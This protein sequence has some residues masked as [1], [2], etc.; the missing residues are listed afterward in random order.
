MQT[1]KECLTGRNKPSLG[2][3]LKKQKK[4]RKKPLGCTY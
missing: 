1:W 3:K 2:P 4:E